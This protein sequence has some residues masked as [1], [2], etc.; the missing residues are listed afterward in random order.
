MCSVVLHWTV[1]QMIEN[2]IGKFLTEW[3]K[4]RP[5]NH[6]EKMWVSFEII[7]PCTASSW[8]S[9]WEKKNSK[10]VH[11]C[12]FWVFFYLSLYSKTVWLAES[13]SKITFTYYEKIFSNIKKKLSHFQKGLEIK[14]ISLF[15]RDYHYFYRDTSH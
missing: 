7:I 3:N 6:F 4:K 8:F 15:H 9:L 2:P 10:C 13:L 11:N 5:H 12:S 14:N 1:C